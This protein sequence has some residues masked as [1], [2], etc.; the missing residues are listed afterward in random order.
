MINL[1]RF[2]A[3]NTQYGKSAGDELL[4]RVARHLETAVGS[5]GAV[6]HAN[7]D[8][9]LVILEGFDASRAR[10][11]ISAVCAQLAK[12]EFRWSS[13]VL[14]VT[15]SAGIADLHADSERPFNLLVTQAD[16]ACQAAKEAGRN[17]TLVFT[18]ELSQNETLVDS[19][20]WTRRIT[21][22]LQED[23]FHLT[24]QF[25]ASS[26]T[27]ESEGDVFDMQVAL[28]DEEGFWAEPAVF[29]PVAERLQLSPQIDRWIVNQTLIQL[30]Q[31]PTRLS[32]IGRVRLRLSPSTVIDP[33]WLNFLVSAF[34]THGVPARQIC[35]ELPHLDMSRGQ[36]ALLP[37]CDAMRAIGCQLSGPHPIALA[38][39]E[40]RDWRHLRLDEVVFDAGTLAGLQ[41]DAAERLMAEQALQLARVR[42][43]RLLVR[44][45]HDPEMLKAWQLLGADYLEGSA[46][47]RSTPLLFNTAR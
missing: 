28:E 8:E 19:G 16:A 46:V 35:F 21:A 40:R 2:D 27:L 26:K 47:A 23:R 34:E 20:L 15:A 14:S 39:T 4:H 31:N 6:Y 38:A 22:G 7:A 30:A 17:T 18:T 3:I 42:K 11:L 25:I 37:F 1:D 29:M 33:E 41:T 43:Q 13:K 32:S 36:A 12:A 9:F 24:T 45:L 10:A 44:N 5:S